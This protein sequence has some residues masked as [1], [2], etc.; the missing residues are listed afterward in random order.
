M[1]LK[2]SSSVR[3]SAGRR[4]AGLEGSGYKVTRQNVEV[5]RV[6]AVAIAPE[7]MAAPAIT[8]IE[9]LAGV[10]VPVPFADVGFLPGEA[11]AAPRT[12]A[13]RSGNCLALCVR[14]VIH[15][16]RR[17]RNQT[18]SCWFSRRGR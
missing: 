10:R 12:I 18:A 6:F 8:V 15:L 2:R 1:A 9:M 17:N 16:R 13:A 14:T 11:K 5:G 3:Q 4:G 7:A